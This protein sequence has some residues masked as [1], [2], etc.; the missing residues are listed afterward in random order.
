MGGALAALVGMATAS[1]GRSRTGTVGG[2]TTGTAIPSMAA[3]RALAISP[4]EEK[5]S[6]GSLARALWITAATP[7][8]KSGFS[9]RRK[10]G[11]SYTWAC[12]TDAV[13]PVKGACPASIS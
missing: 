13:V 1:T 6:A 12:S 4:A 7:S 9:S 5:R 8:G 10:G 11:S 2:G 3:L